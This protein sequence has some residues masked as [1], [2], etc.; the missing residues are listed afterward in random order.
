[1]I[2]RSL[3]AVG[4]AF[5][6]ALALPAAPASAGGGGCAEVTEGT[7]A[8]VELLYACITPSLI[9]VDPG[10]EVTFV[11]RDSFR[12]VIAAAGY[13]WGSD[14]YMREGEAFAATF[15]RSGVYPFQCYLHPGMA[16]A[17]IVGDATG[18][19]PASRG[20]VT[21]RPVVAKATP[22]TPATN[23]EGTPATGWIGGG[24]LGIAV[25]AGAVLLARRREPSAAGLSRSG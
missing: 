17:V 1:M 16:G 14:G 18:L 12:H 15:E 22:A 8:T 13:G 4:T 11:N 2:R 3:A 9:R 6:I 25:G 24:L 20:S 23:E 5:V 19:G 7:G 10:D 21:V